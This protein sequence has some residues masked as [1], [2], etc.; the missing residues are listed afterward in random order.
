MTT[1]T[2]PLPFYST[3][4]KSGWN[5]LI[6]MF[7][8]VSFCR[9]DSHLYEYPAAYTRPKPVRPPPRPPVSTD[10]TSSK[11][12]AEV[13]GANRCVSSNTETT[14]RVYGILN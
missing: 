3:E 7:S 11:P 12:T 6:S 9:Q 1:K 10:V 13:D 4:I 14:V 8:F 5:L 2:S